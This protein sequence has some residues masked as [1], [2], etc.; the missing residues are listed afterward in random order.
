MPQ[1]T[2]GPRVLGLGVSMQSGRALADEYRVS[3]TATLVRIARVAPGRHAVVHW[4]MKN[5]PTE[6]R[7]K[8]PENQLSLFD[9]APVKVL[10][11]KL[12]VEWA[13]SGPN[14]GYV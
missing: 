6:V 1:H 2:F 3:L 10:P 11:K 9:D 13:L 14:V 8:V 4:R 7:G 5:K 12:R